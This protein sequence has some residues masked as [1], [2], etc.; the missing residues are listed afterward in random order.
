MKC[1]KGYGRNSERN[2]KSNRHEEDNLLFR[3]GIIWTREVVV[4][5]WDYDIQ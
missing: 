3:G 1:H 4:G 5:K 2:P